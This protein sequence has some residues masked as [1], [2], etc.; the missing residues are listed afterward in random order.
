METKLVLN[1]FAILFF[2]LQ[3]AISEKLGKNLTIQQ[4]KNHLVMLDTGCG[5]GCYGSIAG[6]QGGKVLS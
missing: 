3:L 2:F 6:N 1:E 5:F 4:Q